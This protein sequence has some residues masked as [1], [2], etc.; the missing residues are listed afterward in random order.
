MRA[1]AARK[2]RKES[3]MKPSQSDVGINPIGSSRINFYIFTKS[4]ILLRYFSDIILS[5]ALDFSKT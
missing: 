5:L 4:K 1:I 3:F 2:T